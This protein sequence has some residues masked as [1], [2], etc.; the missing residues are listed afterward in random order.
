MA[1]TLATWNVNS[2][3]V[4]LTHLLDWLARQRTDVVCLQ[5][6]KLV[7]EKFP[8]KELSDAGY[9]SAFIGQKTYN[10]VAILTRR[11]TVGVASDIQF[12]LP[13]YAD[14]Q[15]RLIVATVANIRVLCAYFP[16]GQEVGSEKFTY[17]LGWIEA[18]TS[19]V[20]HELS[21]HAQLALAGDYNVA[22]EERD[23]HDPALWE[24]KVLFSEAERQAFRA[25]IGLGLTDSFRLF[26]QPP[27]SY[28]WW[29]YRMLAFRRKAGLRID[30]IL[31]SSALAARCT[32]CTIDVEP[33]RLEQPSDHAPVVA[34]FD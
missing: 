10:G 30:H 17:K 9:A 32:A 28:S 15:R 14:E 22:P 4:R 29:D 6:T 19:F 26:D 2:L 18:L 23:V 12:G 24:G 8:A 11:D 20:R 13:D 1:L 27:R 5:E 7:D 31:L 33:R 34:T 25:L 21:Q 16:N 3:K